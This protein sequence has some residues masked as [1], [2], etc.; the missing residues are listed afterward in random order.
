MASRT[1][2]AAR[3]YAMLEPD[4]RRGR[5]GAR[6]LFFSICAGV[7]AAIALSTV[8]HIAAPQALPPQPKL[9]FD[10]VSIKPVQ[11]ATGGA[12]DNF[13]KNGSW[14]GKAMDVNA[15]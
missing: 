9:R 13:P 1:D 12:W 11:G 5:V 6:A 3:I 4:A 10:V 8:H 2:L 15:I 7:L 14:T